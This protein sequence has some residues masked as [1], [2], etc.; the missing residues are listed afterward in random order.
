M[1]LINSKLKYIL[2]LIVGSFVSKTV[3][4]QINYQIWIN[5]AWNTTP[6][7]S[8]NFTID[9]SP[10][11]PDRFYKATVF[12]KDGK[13]Y[14]NQLI[15]LYLPENMVLFLGKNQKEMIT[16]DPIFKVMFTDAENDVL[17]MVFESGF[18][19]S[20]KLTSKTFYQVL[21]TGKAKLLKHIFVDFMD[22]KGHPE[23]NITRYYTQKNTYYISINKGVPLKLEKGKDGI[24]KLLADKK[25]QVEQ[26]IA[27]N[28]L[29]CKL[30]EDWKLVVD[31]YNNLKD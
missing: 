8:T 13:F 10:F 4:S 1:S 23:T 25:N 7:L 2:I 21:E 18:E 11:I 5:E 29:K 19:A 28:K 12:L 30:E 3:Q 31:Y 9:G 26:Y 16:T 6:L 20:D 24:V 22:Q 14:E 27:N 17:G 15:K